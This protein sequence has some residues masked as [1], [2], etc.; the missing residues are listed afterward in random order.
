[1]N[2]LNL[3]YIAGFFDGEGCIS[4]SLHGLRVILTNTDKKIL[5]EIQAYF[6]SKGQITSKIRNSKDKATKPC[7]QLIYWNR[8]AEK[9]VVILM[10]YLRQKRKQAKL[11]LEFQKTYSLWGELKGRARKYNLMPI[12]LEKRIGL[13]N[14]MKKLRKSHV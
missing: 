1:M 4:L 2:K 14:D 3:D 13:I 7:W 12:V 9:V 10:P 8:Q 5:K 6:N 11:A